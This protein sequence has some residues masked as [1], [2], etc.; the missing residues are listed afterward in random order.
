MI[1]ARIATN[2][3]YFSGMCASGGVVKVVHRVPPNDTPDGRV[4]QMKVNEALVTQMQL[5]IQLREI[6]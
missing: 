4:A 5:L 1:L 3:P 2:T 6:H